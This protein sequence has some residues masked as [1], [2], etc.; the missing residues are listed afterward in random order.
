MVTKWVQ[1]IYIFS[2]SSRNFEKKKIGEI[3]IEIILKSLEKR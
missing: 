2:K 1:L 3:V